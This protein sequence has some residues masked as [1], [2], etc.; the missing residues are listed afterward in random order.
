MP[1]LANG[2]LA[3]VALVDA[4]PGDLHDHLRILV[5]LRE[6]HAGDLVI[7]DA[8]AVAPG[9]AA[10]EELLLR[11]RRDVLC[12]H[13]HAAEARVDVELR[14]GLWHAGLR[15]LSCATEEEECGGQTDG[16]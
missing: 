15:R 1:F 12:G 3:E 8:H 13:L 14:R 7:R 2:G 9:L 5:A 6:P 11:L 10:L 4:I 16:E